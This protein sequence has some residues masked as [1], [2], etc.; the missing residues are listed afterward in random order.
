MK[1]KGRSEREV[2]AGVMAYLSLRQDCFCFRA[3]T[4]AA[5]FGGY[6]VSFGLP[7]AAD[8]QCVQ[9]PTGRFVGIELKRELGGKVSGD[10]ERWG[11]AVESAG[12][13]YIVARDVDTVARALGPEQAR[14]VKPGKKR[15]YPR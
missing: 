1:S 2:S 5:K 4:G 3:N 7:G 9:G 15:N 11:A 6:F 10:Q 8:I 13:L 12:G 14:V